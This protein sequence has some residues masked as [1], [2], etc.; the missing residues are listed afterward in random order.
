M[1]DTL[2]NSVEPDE[3]LYKVAFDQGP[4]NCQDKNNLHV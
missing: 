2:A 1:N 4:E 3:M